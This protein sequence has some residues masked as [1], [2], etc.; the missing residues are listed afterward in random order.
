M[1]VGLTVKWHSGDEDESKMFLNV[2]LWRVWE[3]T[4]TIGVLIRRRGGGKDELFL[5]GSGGG[6]EDNRD[7]PLLVF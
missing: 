3:R 2:V 7:R 6:R 1:T 5:E 4:E